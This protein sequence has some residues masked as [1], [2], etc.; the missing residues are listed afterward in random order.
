MRA[1]RITLITLAMQLQPVACY[2]KA[3]H[4]I[5]SKQKT[6]PEVQN[7]LAWQKS[8]IKVGIEI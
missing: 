7:A 6:S 2:L 5:T 1:N 8:G 3:M 4:R